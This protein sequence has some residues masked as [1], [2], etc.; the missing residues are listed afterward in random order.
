MRNSG[1]ELTLHRDN[2]KFITEWGAPLLDSGKLRKL[3]S[4]FANPCGGS[5][6]C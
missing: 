3:R 1:K 6:E 5:G 2:A 4:S